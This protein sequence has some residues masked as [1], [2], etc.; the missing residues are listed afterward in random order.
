MLKIMKNDSQITFSRGQQSQITIKLHARSFEVIHEL[1]I[2][3]C[4]PKWSKVPRSKEENEFYLNLVDN[5]S[6]WLG[7]KPEEFNLFKNKFAEKVRDDSESPT[8]AN[9]DGSWEK[10]DKEEEHSVVQG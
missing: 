10:V 9:L 6:I 2:H 7:V 8:I 5:G 4:I 1:F 3:N